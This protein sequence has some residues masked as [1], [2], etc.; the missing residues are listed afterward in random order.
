M[1]KHSVLLT[2]IPAW[3]L[4][5]LLGLSLPGSAAAP[6]E[7]PQAPRKKIGIVLEGGG[8][9]GLSHIGVLQWMEEHHVPVDYV[10]GTSMGGLVGGAYATGMRPVEIREL[11]A[12][13]NW[14][15]VLRGNSEF[16]DLSF[17]R[18]EDIQ[19]YP[20]PLEFGL[21][22]GPSIPAAFNTGQQVDYILDRIA[23]PYST[24]QSFDDL[25]L[26]FRCVATDL[27]ARNKHVFRDGSL[28]QALRATMSLPGFFTP[29]KDEGRIYVDGGLLDNLP[30]DV[31]KEMGAETIIAVH[32]DAAPLPPNAALSSF[33]T[34]AQSF[35]AVIAVNERR[36]MELADVL[37]R[38]DLTKYNST[39]YTI[40][41]QMISEGYMAAERSGPALLKFA[42]DDQDWKTYLE[43]RE[44]RRVRAVPV[45]AFVQVSGLE[46]R[47]A[48]KVEHQ[49]QHYEGQAINQ[50][51]LEQELN[52]VAGT[53]RFS[54]M[55]YSITEVDQRFG[56]HV[57]A[58]EKD[59]GPPMVNPI[60]LVDGSQYNNVL[61]SAGGRLTLMD[62]G[63][64]GAELRTDLI[65]GSTY[66]AFSEY[67]TPIRQSTRWFAA[68][69]ANISSVPL[70][71]Y[72]QNTQLAGYRRVETT[73][74]FDLGYMFD[75][76]SE[77]RLGYEA[78]WQS[79]SLTSGSSK[80]L[81]S[82]SGT[83]S[84]ARIRYALN[85]LDDPVVP[86]KGAGAVSE[87]HFYDSRPGAQE[88]VPALY[89]SLEFFQP[90]SRRDSIYF[91]ATEGTTF[92]V[93]QTGIPPFT[94]GGALRLSA[95]GTNEIFT[96]QYALFQ[97]GNLRRI[98][99]LPPIVGNRVYLATFGELARPQ[100]SQIPLL[101]GF[102]DLPVDA[103]GAILA[104]TLLGPM[105]MGGAW[106]DSGHRKV[107]FGLG[108]VF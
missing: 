65:A 75:R 74:G 26:P 108:R 24:V 89:T 62:L 58:L 69:R 71:L 52:I 54:N 76:F 98:G 93:K 63:K 45:P 42:L 73:G 35:A 46:P 21:R 105:Y 102:P 18:K 70:E 16:A 72:Q 43:A 101:N 20:N 81:P 37:V 22:H 13:I 79:Y 12:N 99:Q 27:V 91:T 103:A 104:E 88:N 15:A 1:K 57:K 78:G 23:L 83:L 6:Q 38:V 47:Y 68:P 17:R 82:V 11:V 5:L 39:Q 60:I 51:R 31:A 19:A 14:D 55:A 64:P 33:A 85:R 36:G 87:F 4:P 96:N 48:R 2:A 32:L 41:D 50:S 90:V 28:A 34:L 3:L 44:A 49:L 10:A 40:A 94:L 30:T 80:F 8:A 77:V 100:K 106:G 66:Q 61:F 84:S 53:G 9:L 59:Y 107:F 86:R 95:Y 25:P 97:A 67:F 56:L 7:V 29:V 92:G